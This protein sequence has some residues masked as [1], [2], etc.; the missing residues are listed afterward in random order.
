MVPQSNKSLS[1]FCME[2]QKNSNMMKVAIDLYQDLYPDVQVE[3]VMLGSALSSTENLEE[4]YEQVAAQ[5]MA[6]EGPDVFVIDD[7]VMDVEKLVRQGV[8][9]DMEP[10]FEADNFDWSSY[11]KTIMDGGVWNGKRFVVP[12]SYDFPLL[13]TS[14]TALEEAGFDRNACKDYQGFLEETTR[15]M[16]DLTQ[17]RQLFRQP[18]MITDIVGFSG[19]TI[20]DYDGRTVDLSDPLFKAGYQWYKTVMER[21]IY[22]FN[23]YTSDAS[24]SG[25]AA[26]RDG[27]VLWTPPLEGAINGFYND[28]SAIK[29]VD[30]A[31]M[32][33]I[34]DMN[35]GIQARVKFPV[36]VRANSENLQNAY[37]FIK[38]LLSEQVQY[39][40]SS[41]QLSVYYPANTY[42][43]QRISEGKM[44]H[45]LAGTN[46]F[47]STENQH[48]ALDWPSTEEFEE[49]IGYTR[50]I[51]GTFYRN[52]LGL[53]S[54]MNPYV[55]E[56]ADYDAT[57]AEAQRQLERYI[58]E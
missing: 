2:S 52:H 24:L 28:F 39:T 4:L 41:E 11:Q 35:G 8:F 53:G 34:R 32:M 48:E 6:G 30:Q 45:I 12:L 26:V 54:A 18:L 14:Q 20:A 22:S 43:F 44:Y 16:E 42:F 56:G 10:F 1:V 19:I 51:T 36:A 40:I 7:S 49:F 13:F 47:T 55:Y 17:T 9:A 46:G 3:L 15:Y 33:P 25:A 5:I 27:N 29:T 50:E 37:N 58:T 23:D 21:N 31:V 38:I 57:L